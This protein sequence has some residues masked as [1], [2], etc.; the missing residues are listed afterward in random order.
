MYGLIRAC[1]QVA[2]I[3]IMVHSAKI[4]GPRAHLND[5]LERLPKQ[6]ASKVEELSPHP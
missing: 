2:A 6:A 1:Q 5:A 3:M 4:N